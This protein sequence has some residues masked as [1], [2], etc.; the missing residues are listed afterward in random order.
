M[1]N[2]G[3]SFRGDR[4]AKQKSREMQKILQLMQQYEVLLNFLKQHGALLSS[5]RLQ[6][7]PWDVGGGGPS[8]C[9]TSHEL[10]CGS[11]GNP[12]RHRLVAEVGADDMDEVEKK[13][14]PE[15]QS[16]ASDAAPDVHLRPAGSTALHV[17]F[18][19]L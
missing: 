19:L 17:F 6:D 7:V 11:P 16:R 2:T 9:T 13:N 18:S 1:D 5:V 10:S 3:S 4:G 14:S 8:S 12:R 15:L